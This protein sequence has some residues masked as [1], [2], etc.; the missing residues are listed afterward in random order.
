MARPARAP[1]PL[2]AATSAAALFAATCEALAAAPA[3]LSAEAPAGAAPVAILLSG[4]LDR[5]LV[6]P[7]LENLV[8]ANV[9]AGTPVDIFFGMKPQMDG[10]NYASNKGESKWLV[11]EAGSQKYV[12]DP[13]L[14]RLRATNV[15]NKELFGRLCEWSLEA[16]AGRCVTEEEA[17][18]PLELPDDEVHR[19]IMSYYNPISTATGQNVLRRWRTIDRLLNKAKDAELAH[20]FR[21]NSV[22]I[23]RD[24]NYWLT[25]YIFDTT[26][27]EA[28]PS[29]LR[30]TSRLEAH[31]INDK[32]LHLGRDAVDRMGALYQ[33]WKRVPH[34]ALRD[35]RNAEEFL[36]KLAML[37]G[38]GIRPTGFKYALAS[39]T[40]SGIPCYRKQ[41]YNLTDK[42]G[43]HK[44]HDEATE[45]GPVTKLFRT[46]SCDTMNP[47]FFDALS[48]DEVAALRGTIL[49][50]SG[51]AG[52]VSVVF[53]ISDLADI[54]KAVIT[55]ASLRSADPS[56]RAVVVTRAQGCERIR[57]AAGNSACVELPRVLDDQRV[58]V[59]LLTTAVFSGAA[60]GILF[61]EPGVK[62]QED[63]VAAFTDVSGG[64]D[65][66][67]APRQA[68][69]CDAL[70]ASADVSSSLFYVKSTPGGSH[71]LM[72]AWMFLAEQK[73]PGGYYVGERVALG[74]D[75]TLSGV[76]LNAGDAGTV[77]GPSQKDL[78][79]V[80]VDLDRLPSGSGLALL[81][82]QLSPRGSRSLL[83]RAVA[84]SAGVR[85]A[86]TRCGRLGWAHL[87]EEE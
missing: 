36:F 76:S 54:D 25:P 57:R 78:E 26:D 5:L 58:K 4:M 61:A 23:A 62:F 8:R 41:S 87:P 27:F 45:D 37:E 82:R 66:V 71:A 18:E 11:A 43:Y 56:A 21:Y 86:A 79:R 15:S 16:G 29:I 33:A 83:A 46:F 85:A 19:S 73:L 81:P 2:L 17:E 65:V 40:E 50:A 49:E 70:A 67:F 48:S 74:I 75:F 28:R 69:Q 3:E 44:C 80:V 1:L 10:Q 53:T 52:N 24:D 12:K 38:V 59:A 34:D 72:R 60:G 9:D 22:L 63:P 64:H 31:G 84:A 7:L 77:R 30:S 47:V 6:T 68:A 35:T 32:T 13:R 51:R 42:G 20:G 55:L 14:T 39:L